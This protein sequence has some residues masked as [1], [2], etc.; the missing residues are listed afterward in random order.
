MGNGSWQKSIVSS[1]HE[2]IGESKRGG[3]HC[4]SKVKK[5]KV[6][7]VTSWLGGVVKK[8]PRPLSFK[9]LLCVDYHITHL[10]GG[11]RGGFYC[12]LVFSLGAFYF[13]GFFLFLG[14]ATARGEEWR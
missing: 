13:V 3:W 2:W 7:I 12:S 10:E 9:S 1:W 6:L 11:G 14:S 5:K 4:L 8:S